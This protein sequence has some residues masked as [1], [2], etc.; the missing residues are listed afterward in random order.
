MTARGD[1]R[2]SI[3]DAHAI[4]APLRAVVT[5]AHA[6]ALSPTA[7]F[8]EA[9]PREFVLS[10]IKPAEDGKGVIVRDHNL[11]DEAVDT[12][13]KVR[14]KFARAARVNLN[15]EEIAPAELNDGSEV[16]LQVRAKEIVTLKFEP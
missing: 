15:E 9:S 4:A 14:R 2:N 13:I 12:R 3:A 1:W 6:G 5:D 10:A 16:V 11:G 7:S 8:I